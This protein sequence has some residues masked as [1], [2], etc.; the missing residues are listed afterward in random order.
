MTDHVFTSPI[1]LSK[2]L[3]GDQIFFLQNLLLIDVICTLKT[4]YS[5]VERQRKVIASTLFGL[6]SHPK[7]ISLSKFEMLSLQKLLH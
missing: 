3:E 4:R 5:S 6:L 2:E 1:P 7:V